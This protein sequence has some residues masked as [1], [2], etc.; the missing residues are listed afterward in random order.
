MF[1][2]FGIFFQLLIPILKI[3]LQSHAIIAYC[4]IYFSNAVVA[5]AAVEVGVGVGLI[6]LNNLSK[7][8]N[9]FFIS[10][11]SFVADAAVVEC[12]NIDA[13]KIYNL[14]IVSNSM[15]ILLHLRQTVSSVVKCFY[16]LYDSIV[17]HR[18]MLNLQRIVINRFVEFFKFAVDKASV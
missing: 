14:R 17:S 10:A 2:F 13:I 3:Q 5:A 6:N 11:Q 18:T 8:I 15:L 7:I 16:V 1:L 9:R 12:V 4:Q